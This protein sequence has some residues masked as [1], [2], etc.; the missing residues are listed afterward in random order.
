M[1]MAQSCLDEK[2]LDYL[3]LLRDQILM[4]GWVVGVHGS[5]FNGG[6]SAI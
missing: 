5:G 1:S 3:E 4:S 2:V 6:D